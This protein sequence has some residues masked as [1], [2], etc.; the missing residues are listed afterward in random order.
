MGTRR[1]EAI[2]NPFFFGRLKK[3]LFVEDSLVFHVEEAWTCGQLTHDDA[4]S[5]TEE[6]S[7]ISNSH[8]WAEE[9]QRIPASRAMKLY[10]HRTNNNPVLEFTLT[11]T[12]VIV[13]T[14]VQLVAPKD[15]DHLVHGSIKQEQGL[16]RSSYHGIMAR[17][18]HL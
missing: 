6:V 1:K 7:F 9:S 12:S 10:L 11:L 8:R 3:F 5:R 2:P 14:L 18:L 15:G 4:P 16:R 13:V 17:F